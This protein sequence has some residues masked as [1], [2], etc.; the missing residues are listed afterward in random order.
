MAIRPKRLF[1]LSFG[2]GFFLIAA[3]AVT[4]TLGGTWSLARLTQQ[5]LEAEVKHRGIS[6]ARQSASQ[7]YEH[8]EHN[9]SLMLSSLSDGMLRE[10]DLRYVILTDRQGKILS[11]NSRLSWRPMSMP[12]ELRASVCQSADAIIHP[13]QIGHE[14]LY[15]IAVRL[16]PLNAAIE[17]DSSEIGIETACAG[18]LHL[19]LSRKQLIQHQRSVQMLAW[20][21]S[22]FS[23][24]T[25]VT[26]YFLLRVTL[27]RP[28]TA[29][30]EAYGKMP[31]DECRQELEAVLGYGEI[32]SLKTSLLAAE[33]L[34]SERAKRSQQ[35]RIHIHGHTDT[36]LENNQQQ[37]DALEHQR[38]ALDKLSGQALTTAQNFDNLGE[39]TQNAVEMA[40]KSI[41]HTVNMGD[42]VG[43]AISNIDEIRKQ[44]ATNMDRI[45]ELGEKIGQISN[46]V[47]M[48]ETIAAQ[49]K[50]IAVNA[51]IEAAG[52]GEAGGRFSIVATEV[53]RLANTVVESVEKIKESVSS[54]QTATSELIL[55]SETGIRKVNQGVLQIR[56]TR[57]TLIQM[58]ELL[59][60]N[61]LTL[62][63]LLESIRFQGI[64]QQFV[65]NGL[66][67]ISSQFEDAVERIKHS[68]DIVREL[69]TMVEEME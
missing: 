57:E 2:F 18:A 25:A 47:K 30:S 19:G 63:E 65:V 41:T 24:F 23:I 34:Q 45:V 67:D 33:S 40:E 60:K 8:L 55:S 13:R 59:E 56:A 15:D 32:G 11:S 21:I 49:T 69:G 66:K 39:R 64:Q 10:K 62:D 12:N 20:G 46:V 17:E 22:L 29:L 28:V 52:A 51:S 4:V 3:I 48:I 27:I 53:R 9:D 44:V 14:E 68:H 58:S 35:C 5:W 6:L 1:K 61:S 42:S 31:S 43:R 37:A 26:G 38:R 16:V 7:L 54:V 36:L 50:L